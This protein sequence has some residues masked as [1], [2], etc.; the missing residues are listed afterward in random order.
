MIEQE[1]VPNEVEEKP[2]NFVLTIQDAN[3]Y[4]GREN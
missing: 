4:T 1:Y 2:D 3:C